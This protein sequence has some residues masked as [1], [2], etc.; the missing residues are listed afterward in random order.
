MPFCSFERT[1]TTQES[2]EVVYYWWSRL[3]EVEQVCKFV[4]LPSS[5][6]LI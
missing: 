4:P 3:F 6:V 2:A 1:S 5:D